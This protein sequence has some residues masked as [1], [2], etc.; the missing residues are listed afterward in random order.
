MGAL[1]PSPPSGERVGVRGQTPPAFSSVEEGM[2]RTLA[3]S[4]DGG[5]GT[6]YAEGTYGRPCSLVVLLLCVPGAIRAPGGS[7]AASAERLRAGSRGRRAVR[8][9]A[10]ARRDPPPADSGPPGR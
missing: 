2:I 7:R 8:D 1:A 3:L 6:W 9:G 4:P 10:P 5:G